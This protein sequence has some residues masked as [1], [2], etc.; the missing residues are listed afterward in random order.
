MRYHITVSWVAVRWSVVLSVLVASLMPATA[1]AQHHSGVSS[2]QMRQRYDKTTKGGSSDANID[3]AVKQLKSSDANKRLAAVKSLGSSKDEK[4]VTYLIE[5]TGDPDLRVQAKA[6]Q[7]LGDVRA[8]DA[9]PVLVQYLF[10]R[11]TRAEM[12]QLIL[13]SIGKIGDARAT[14][15]LMEFLQRDLDPATRGTVIFALGEIGSPEAVETLQTIA[16]V[17]TDQSVRR[18]A[19]EAKSKVEQHQAA[20]NS[21]VKGPAETFLEPKDGSQPKRR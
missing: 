16:Q 3:D 19:S 6:V 12:K 2:N 18:L 17:D 7:M 9:T 13:A 10:L 1:V 20:I 4:A 21:Q 5:A 8:T 15:P 14:R 11:S